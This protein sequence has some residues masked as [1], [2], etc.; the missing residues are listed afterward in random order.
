MTEI[1][2]PASRLTAVLPLLAAAIVSGCGPSSDEPMAEAP[3]AMDASLHGAADTFAG[4]SVERMAADPAALALGDELYA[5]RCESCHGADGRGKPGVMN[6][7]AGVFNYG[8]DVA[9]IGTTIAAG[10]QSTMPAFGRE[11]GEMALSWMAEYLDSLASDEP[12]SRFAA[13]GAEEFAQS[14]AECHGADARG[15]PTLGAPNLADDYWL[16]SDD[17]M[18]IRQ[19]VMRGVD[20][21]CPAQRDALSATAIDLL[22]AHVLRRR[23]S[24]T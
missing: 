17:T 12:L 18:G 13:R 21:Q 15:N 8:D 1:T 19:I 14:C 22:T 20:S 5:A 24:G 10:R 7:T 11:L 2:A 4:W 3:A 9:A 23:H 16:H 6:L